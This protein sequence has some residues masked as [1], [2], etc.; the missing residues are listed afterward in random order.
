MSL[1]RALEVIA[2]KQ[3]ADANRLIHDFGVDDIQLLNGRYGPYITDKKKNAR[4][5]KGREP[6]SL[7]LEECR[8]L[9]AAAPLKGTRG[10][11]GRKLTPAAAKV[12]VAAAPP[13]AATSPKSK[14]KTKGKTARPA[15]SA[16]PAAAKRTAARTKAPAKAPAKPARAGLTAGK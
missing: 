9:L 8:A 11:F 2:A 5:P 16:R 1:E 14:S 12:T 15:R 7:T 3:L 6:K 4:I 13:A 10:R